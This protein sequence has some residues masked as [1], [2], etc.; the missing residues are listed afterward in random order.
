MNQAL[1]HGLPAVVVAAALYGSSP[2]LQAASARRASPG[3]G[4]GF[5]LLA[6]LALQ[7]L[8][9]LGLVTA[10]GAFALEAYAFSVAPATLVAPLITLDMVFLVLLAR[11][12]LNERLGIAGALGILAMALGT[13]LIA[14]AFSG[15]A[16]LGAPASHAQMLAFLVGGAAVAGAAASVGDHGIR[17]GRSWLAAIGFG[18]ASGVASGIAT[19]CTRQ[20]GL[21]FDVHDPWPI[22][23]TPTPYVLL[24]ASILSLSLLQRGLQSGASVLVFPVASFMSALV[25]V[26]IG[27]TVLDDEVPSNGQGAAFVI[28]LLAVAVGV[29]LLARDHAAAEDSMEGTDLRV[30]ETA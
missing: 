15:D 29:A 13:A 1:T 4:L 18:A 2:V 14:F 6:R 21:T 11:H 20:V 5:R 8:W 26:L 24:A 27:I 19:L 7:P 9:L 30:G 10:L 23:T 28:A 12:K 25:L 3:A 16:A 17:T 22:L